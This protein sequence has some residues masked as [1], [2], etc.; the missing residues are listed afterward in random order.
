MSAPTIVYLHGFNSSPQSVKARVIAR[1]AAALALRRASTCPQLAHRPA[2]AMRDVCA[3]IESAHARRAELALVGSSLG[4]YLR[5]VARG[6]LR[7]EGGRDQSGDPAAEDLAP[8][9]G[10]QRNLYTG[11]RIRSHARALRRARGARR[12]ADHASRSAISCSLVPATS[13]SIGATA[14]AFYAGAF[15]Y[16]A[17]GGNHGW[18]DFERRSRIGAALLRMRD[19][20]GHLPMTPR[21]RRDRRRGLVGAAVAFGLRSLGPK[22]ALLDEGDVAYRAARANFGLIWVQG[23]GRASLVRVLDAALGAR[24]AAARERASARI[25]VSTSRLRNRAASMSASR[26]KELEQRVAMLDAAAV[27][28][29]LPPV[30]DRS[31]RSRRAAHRACPVSGRRSPAEHIA[32]STATAIR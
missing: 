32:R 31:P 16:V 15:Q 8:F 4:G 22:L 23:K 24:V 2:E 5:D 25:P 27:A 1:A 30:S 28:A 12:R 20:P 14:V 3:W 21:R 29:G 26:A 10:P 9:V 19:S 18:E 13:S 6:A 11:D 7:R 17:G